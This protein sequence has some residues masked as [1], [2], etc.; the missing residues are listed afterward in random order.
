M[1]FEFQFRFGFLVRFGYNLVV[2]SA[3]SSNLVVKF[4]F[5][6]ISY[7][8]WVN[9][10]NISSWISHHQQIFGQLVVQ[11]LFFFF[12]D[13]GFWCILSY[14]S[15]LVIFYFFV[16]SFIFIHYDC[17][18]NSYCMKGVNYI[19]TPTVSL[20]A[21]FLIRILSLIL[22]W[23]VNY[24]NLVNWSNFLLLLVVLWI[25]DLSRWSGNIVSRE[26]FMFWMNSI[27]LVW[28]AWFSKG[29]HNL[30]IRLAAI[31]RYLR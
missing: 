8:V 18:W 31:G 14:V 30:L 13:Y 29:Y 12:I 3:Y 23:L 4:E 5:N 24:V 27:Y 25:W 1:N 20:F 16:C 17:R 21:I 19:V 11:V 9:F 7:L 2:Y 22:F 28:N 15:A 10:S 26:D 6:F